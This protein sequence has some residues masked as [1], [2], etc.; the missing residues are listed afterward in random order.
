MRFNSVIFGTFLHSY[1][2][3]KILGYFVHA[4]QVKLDMHG[5]G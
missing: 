2:F 3:K 1:K 4:E 5:K